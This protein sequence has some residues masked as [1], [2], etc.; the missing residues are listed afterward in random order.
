PM[1]CP[2]IARFGGLS[3]KREDYAVIA[4]RQIDNG[5]A[6]RCELLTRLLADRCE[7]CGATNKIEVHHV[8]A[9]KDLKVKGKKEKPLWMQTMSALRRKTLIVCRPCHIA[10]HSG[11]PLRVATDM[12]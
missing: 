5:R 3:R 12:S 11:R 4:D 7:I 2:L 1:T 9:L 10:I 6:P 8:R